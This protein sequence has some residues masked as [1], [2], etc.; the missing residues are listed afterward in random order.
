MSR[1]YA[2]N[3]KAKTISILKSNA[4]VRLISREIAELIFKKFPDDCEKKKQRSSVLQTNGDLIGQISAEIG[5][6]WR[7]IVDA[8][9][10]IQFIEVRPR[11]FYWEENNNSNEIETVPETTNLNPKTSKQNTFSEH[12][13]Y[14]I[15]GSVVFNEMRCYSMRIDE[16]AGSNNNGPRG[17]HWLYPDIVGMIPLSEKWNKEVSALAD[18]IATERVHLVSFEVKKDITRSDIREYF[19]QTVSNSSWANFAYLAAVNLKGNAIEELTLLCSSYGVGF[20]QVDLIDPSNS[21]IRIPARFKESI[22][23]NGLN[24]LAIENKD[25]CEYVENISTYIK[26]G[27]LKFSDWNLVPDNQE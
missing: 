4:G 7:T 20:I 2:F 11:Q 23:V 9:E 12:D 17:N 25:A 21:Q 15:L 26:T 8:N 1:N 16:R 18:S 3:L 6:N 19:F 10:N 24:R 22:D 27:R 13:L 5:S 14:P